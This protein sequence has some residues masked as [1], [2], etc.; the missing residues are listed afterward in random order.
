MSSP[1]KYAVQ[2]DKENKATEIKLL[3][4]SRPHMRAFHYAWLSFFLAFTGWFALAPLTPIVRVSLGLCENGDW[5]DFSSPRECICGARCKEAI[6][7]ANTVSVAGTIGM[8]LLVGAWA[9]TYGPRFSQAFMVMLFSIPLALAGAVSNGASLAAVRFFI[10][11]MGATFVITQFWTSVMFSKNVV[12]TANATSAGWGN[13]GGGFTQVFMPWVLSWFIVFGFDL[14]WRLA[15]LVPAVLL[16]F[17]GIALYLTSDDVPEGTY[18]ALYASGE[19]K[20]QNGWKVFLA[21]AIDPRVWLLFIVYGG[22]FG[23]ELTMNNVL[24]SYFFDYFGLS[25]Q[26]AGLAASLFGLMNLF[27]RSLGGIASDLAN[28]HFSHRGRHWVFFAVQLGE[29]CMLVLFSRFKSDNFTG[30]IITLIAFSTMVQ[31]AEGA[32]YAVVPYVG[33]HLKALG[34]VSGIVGAGGNFGAVM[35]SLI[36]KGYAS[37]PDPRQPFLVH[38]ICVVGTAL[39]IPFIHYPEFGSMFLPQTKEEEAQPDEGPTVI[40]PAIAQVSV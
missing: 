34:P 31:M 13:L 26:T 22:C 1:S 35:W 24:A 33:K 2:V 8:R 40:K 9:E 27:A 20:K 7:N 29:G 28:K 36:Y 3:N 6:G 30:A 21:A 4:F 15:V 37:H 10:G 19:R 39:L 25:L 14:A 5:N 38:G 17:V 23:T 18:K 16:F 32:Q 11:G 12:G